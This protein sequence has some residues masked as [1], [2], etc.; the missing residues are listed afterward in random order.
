MPRYAV[1]CSD[2][3]SCHWALP[4]RGI[5]SVSS[6][7]QLLTL[8]SPAAT[9]MLMRYSRCP[10]LP[11]TLPPPAGFIYDLTTHTVAPVEKPEGLLEV[12]VVEARNVPRM[13]FFGKVGRR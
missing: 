3:T 4:Q 12:A 10:C 9:P 11:G 7:R 1:L 13:D 2:G 8:R 6:T 5:Y